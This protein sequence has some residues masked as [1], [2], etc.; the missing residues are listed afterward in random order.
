MD[1]A[2]RQFP[3]QPFQVTQPLDGLAGGGHHQ[4]VVSGKLLFVKPVQRARPEQDVRRQIISEI[5]VI[6]LFS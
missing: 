6:P 4:R 3:A 1:A 5:H 2:Q